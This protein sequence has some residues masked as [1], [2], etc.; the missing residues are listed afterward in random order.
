MSRA[1]D[2]LKEKSPQAICSLRRRGGDEE[3]KSETVFSSETDND[4]TL[5]V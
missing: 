4:F 1:G 5:S 2:F 3:A